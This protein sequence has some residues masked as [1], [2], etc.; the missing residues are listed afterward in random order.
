ML[1][2]LDVAVRLGP[3]EHSAGSAGILPALDVAPR[4]PMSSIGMPAGSTLLTSAVRE[5]STRNRRRNR[6]ECFEN[7]VETR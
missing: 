5:K 1:P 7:D 6:R 2:A 3:S 4:I